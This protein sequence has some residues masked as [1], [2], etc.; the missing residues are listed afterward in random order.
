MKSI[1]PLVNLFLT[2]SIIIILACSC[3]EEKDDNTPPPELYEFMT[4]VGDGFVKLK[5][6]FAGFG[7]Y[8]EYG[9]EVTYYLNG[10]KQVKRSSIGATGEMTISGLTNNISYTFK[11]VYFDAKGNKAEG[12]EFYRTPNTPF[13]IVSPVDEDDYIIENGKIRINVH[14]NR[15]ADTTLTYQYELY[16][17]WC[18]SVNESLVEHSITWLEEG[19][20]LSILTNETK[21]TL[22]PNLPC[23]MILGFQHQ[24]VGGTYYISIK[25][26][27]G[28]LLDAD[29]DGYEGGKA[30]FIFNIK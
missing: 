21:E 2:G 20:V 16:G 1:F 3:T 9:L 5:W 12:F 19:K 27:N 10:E 24:W 4:S 23:D 17:C 25:D 30:E 18:L 28:M 26:I 6:A 11:V 14:F 7:L 15:I 13:V 8:G 22:C 29:K